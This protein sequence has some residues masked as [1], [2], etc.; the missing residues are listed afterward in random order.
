MKYLPLLIALL[1]PFTAHGEENCNT[2]G[3]HFY[4]DPEQEETQ[5]SPVQKKAP[6]PITI[7]PR[8]QIKSI[9][10][11]LNHLKATAIMN[12]SRENV[13]N[14]I[15]FQREQLDRASLFSDQWRR[16]I[17]QNPDMDYS[18]IRP[19]NSLAKRAWLDKRKQQAATTLANLHE[20]YGLFYFY[21]GMDCAQCTA[22]ENAIKPFS[23]KHN[24]HV[25]AV[26]LD[27]TVSPVFPTSQP[28]TGQAARLGVTGEY[29]PALA[30]FDTYTSQIIPVGFG[31]MA[32]D[33]LERR[34]HILT[35]VEVGNDY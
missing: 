16:V 34:I 5:P 10:D 15:R 21:N 30:L 2:L 7:D 8:D 31:A 32:A 24:L 26:T 35:Q 12:P 1:F 11:R 14:Y 9:Q 13:A 27:G 28:D 6:K 25:M 20:R 4:C 3:W 19:T 18:L 29:L 33:E 23:E 17:W 22:F